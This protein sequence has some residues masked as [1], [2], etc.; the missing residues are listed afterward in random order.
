MTDKK[1]SRCGRCCMYQLPGQE[2][3]RCRFLIGKIDF[4]TACRIYKNRIGV[5]IEPGVICTKRLSGLG[6]SM[7][8]IERCTLI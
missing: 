5:M 2:L 7:R 1:C 3:K 4:V 8:P 6:D